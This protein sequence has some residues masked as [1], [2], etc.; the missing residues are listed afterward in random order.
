MDETNKNHIL[1]WKNT[2]ISPT[3][4]D[5]IQY[6]KWFESTK[7]FFFRRLINKMV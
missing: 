3:N 6:Q 5:N 4:N 1:E 7:G 2:G